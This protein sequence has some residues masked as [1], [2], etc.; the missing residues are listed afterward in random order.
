MNALIGVTSCGF[1]DRFTP[2]IA[3]VNHLSKVFLWIASISVD[4]GLN[5]FRIS[6]QHHNH[7]PLAPA[8]KFTQKNPLPAAEQQFPILERHCH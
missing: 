1:V 4:P 8:V 5:D 3:Y 2:S 6:A 7:L